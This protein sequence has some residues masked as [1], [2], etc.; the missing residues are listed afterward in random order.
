VNFDELVLRAQR[1]ASAD[2]CGHIVNLEVVTQTGQHIQTSKTS[3]ARIKLAILRGF[4]RQAAICLTA[5]RRNSSYCGVGRGVLVNRAAKLGRLGL[6]QARTADVLSRFFD[7]LP[8][9]AGFSTLLGRTDGQ[10]AWIGFHR[11]V[12]I[13]QLPLMVELSK[14]AGLS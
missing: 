7:F 8:Q 12:L 4:I 5:C 1:H 6:D 13:V 2:P 11:L 14:K 9:H 3:V 10:V